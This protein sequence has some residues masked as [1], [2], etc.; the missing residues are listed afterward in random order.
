[1]LF[2][3]FGIPTNSATSTLAARCSSVSLRF[4]G[5]RGALI[6]LG[7]VSPK[8]AGGNNGRQSGASHTL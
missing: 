4:V 3:E 2:A 1:M 5:A 7:L 8:I 6:S